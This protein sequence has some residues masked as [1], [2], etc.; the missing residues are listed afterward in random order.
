MNADTETC[1]HKLSTITPQVD[2]CDL[3][4]PGASKFDHEMPGE[5]RHGVEKIAAIQSQDGVRGLMQRF[6]VLRRL[7]SPAEES[8]AEFAGLQINL[9]MKEDVQASVKTAQ[10]VIEEEEATDNDMRQKFGVRWTRSL[11]SSINEP[12]KK[13]MREIEKQLKLAADADDIVRGRIVAMLLMLMIVTAGKIDSKRSLLDLLGLNAEQLD[14][15]V[16]GSGEGGQRSKRLKQ[17]EHA[18]SERKE[19]EEAEERRGS[20][21]GTGRRQGR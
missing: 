11:S 12:L 4:E 16:A 8:A 20:E 17:T 13:D 2:A 3:S 9:D 19:G 7:R 18:A 6:Q 10:R 21:G 5:L 14:G 15:M 1:R